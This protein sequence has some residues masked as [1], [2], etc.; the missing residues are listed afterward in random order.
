M[1][2]GAGGAARSGTGGAVAL[3]GSEASGACRPAG[4]AALSVSP[5]VELRSADFAA[6]PATSVELGT[7]E[8]SILADIPTSLTIGS[9]GAALPA[10]PGFAPINGELGPARSRNPT[11][12]R[13][14]ASFG[15][16][17]TAGR[18]GG[19]AEPGKGTFARS[20]A[21]AM[22][23]A[24]PNPSDVA[25]R[26][27]AARTSAPEGMVWSEEEARSIP[28]AA[29]AITPNAA[30]PYRRR[31]LPAKRPVPWDNVARSAGSDESGGRSSPGRKARGRSL[32]TAV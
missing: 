10:A 8:P 12:S 16:M 1:S 13:S 30:P 22:T 4:T 5:S 26:S 21:G 6:E 19:D 31:R 18:M 27:T 14:C 11:T 28:P 3:A 15:G 7:G 29:S 23:W 2:P 32:S 9:A 24:R 17:T 20:A 25:A